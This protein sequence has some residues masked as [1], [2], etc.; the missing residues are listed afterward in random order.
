MRKL[1]ESVW[2]DIR[3][4]SLGQEVRAET[5]IGDY[6][7]DQ[8]YK[9][10]KEHYETD[11]DDRITIGRNNTGRHITATIFIQNKNRVELSIGEDPSY[12]TCLDIIR[13][14]MFE[15]NVERRIKVF[16]DLIRVEF[17]RT[18]LDLG[19]DTKLLISQHKDRPESRNSIYLRVLEMV[20][21]GLTLQTENPSILCI[22]RKK[23]QEFLGESV[24]GDIRKKS[25]G[26]EERAEDDINRFSYHELYEYLIKVYEGNNGYDID[27]VITINQS[28]TVISID[29]YGEQINLKRRLCFQIQR[30]T[31]ETGW[32]EV[33][34]NVKYGV[35]SP[36]GG[37]RLDDIP[38]YVEN[39]IRSIAEFN[40]EYNKFIYILYPKD[41]KRTTNRFFI[42]ILDKILYEID[43]YS[44]K[45]KTK[46][47]RKQ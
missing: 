41:H 43:H 4:K 16:S 27:K 26:Q 20:I 21:I 29:V 22:K 40:H 45:Y 7:F 5:P 32:G 14:R 46:L 10:L 6:S 1:S 2:G 38:P 30:T 12:A 42:E 15:E 24:W 37:S 33:D 19:D 17:D 23:G 3:K 36:Y 34:N 47:K 18:K 31:R 28:D 13:N 39:E 11:R 8:F 25:L 35:L 44:T 9:Y